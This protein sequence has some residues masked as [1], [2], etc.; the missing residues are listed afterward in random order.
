MGAHNPLTH[1]ILLEVDWWAWRH[2]DPRGC[3]LTP[4]PQSHLKRKLQVNGSELRRQLDELVDAGLLAFRRWDL[5][6][7]EP[8][9]ARVQQ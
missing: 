8:D 9:V 4:C 6:P 3:E 2:P 5:V 7:A 1:R